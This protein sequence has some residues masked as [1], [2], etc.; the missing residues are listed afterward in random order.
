MLHHVSLAVPMLIK[1]SERR[2]A[3]DQCFRKGEEGNEE[4]R[5]GLEQ[6]EIR[7][8]EKGT[9]RFMRAFLFLL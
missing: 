6:S 3:D 4:R 1:F 5:R 8:I 2:K 9:A 7:R